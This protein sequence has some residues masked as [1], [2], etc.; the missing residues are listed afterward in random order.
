MLHRTVLHTYFICKMINLWIFRNDLDILLHRTEIILHYWNCAMRFMRINDISIVW[1]FN[2]F[3][4]A[5]KFDEIYKI[6]MKFFWLQTYLKWFIV[7]IYLTG[8]LS[9]YR[10]ILRSVLIFDAPLIFTAAPS[11]PSELDTRYFFG[12]IY[13]WMW[14]NVYVCNK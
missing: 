12:F 5:L 11:I 4:L 6:L 13:Q 7:L 1:H 14:I 9:R 2:L 3:S 10:W 8:W